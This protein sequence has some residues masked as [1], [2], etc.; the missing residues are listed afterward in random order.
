MTTE[1]NDTLEQYTVNGVGPYAFSFRIFASTD[2]TVT[3]LES[4]DVDPV[5]LATSLYTVTGVNDEDGGSITLTAGAA[6]TYDAYMLDIRSNVAIEQPTSIKN[7][8]SFAPLIH[9]TAFDRLSRQIQDIARKVRA[10]FRYPDNVDLDAVMT[11]RTSWLS[12]YLY[13]NSSGVIEPAS[14]IGSTALTQSLIGETLYPRTAAEIA[15][16]VT[17]VNYSYAPGNVLRYGTNTT[18]GTT[19][20]TTAINNAIA[21]NDDVYIPPG[22]YLITSSIIWRDYVRISGA[23]NATI[24]KGDLAVSFFRSAYGESPAIGQRPVGVVI[25]GLFIQPATA[26]TITA[27][28]IGINVKNSQ[29]CTFKDILMQYTDYGVVV[30]QIGQFL[31]FTRIHAQIHNTAFW[32][33][34]TTGG[35]N[36]ISD[37]SFG[38]NVVALD[39]DGGAWDISKTDCSAI[40]AGTSYCMR[41]GRPGG[42]N[43][44]VHAD[45]MY[46]EGVNSANI[47]LQVEDSVTRSTVSM[48]RHSTLVSIVNNAGENCVIEVPG[49]G[50]YSPLYRAQQIEFAGT[51]D[52]AARARIKSEG[53]SSVSLRNAADSGYADNYCRQII[54]V[55]NH[56]PLKIAIGICSGSLSGFTRTRNKVFARYR[57]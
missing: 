43:T 8:G 2:L 49:Q 23:G 30:D 18:P 38:G 40:L 41:L 36:D 5:T 20:M 4:G 45:K 55:T 9:E 48:H 10:S 19:N 21:A 44:T 26:A 28:S 52:G 7:Q 24:I 53:G 31:R 32:S 34:G 25:S 39:L 47:T 6:T 50:F 17:P 16:G 33:D 42:V 27:G 51:V 35:N 12:K 1:T 15:A 13:M 14:S 11:T 3:A 57:D 29:Y 56:Q 22:T 54:L 46:I 37:C